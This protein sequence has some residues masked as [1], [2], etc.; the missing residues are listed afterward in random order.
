MTKNGS[1]GPTRLTVDLPADVARRLTL[2]A[3]TAR[4]PA[5]AVVVALLERH[6]PRAEATQAKGPHIP[7]S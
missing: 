7:Y 6:L 1:D 5:A 2:A 4:R 3:E